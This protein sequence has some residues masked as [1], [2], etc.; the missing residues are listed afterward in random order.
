MADEEQTIPPGVTR[1]LRALR[2]NWLGAYEITVRGGGIWRATRTD[3]GKPIEAD[4]AAELRAKIRL[5]Y[6]AK[7]VPRA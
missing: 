4:T 5:D 2:R 7:P 3:D 6:A 1:N